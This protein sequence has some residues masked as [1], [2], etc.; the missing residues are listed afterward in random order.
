MYQ[1]LAPPTSGHHGPPI[2]RHSI[3]VYGLFSMMD[4]NMRACSLP[5]D[6]RSAPACPCPSI[7]AGNFHFFALCLMYSSV[8]PSRALHRQL[9]VR[10]GV[11]PNVTFT[12]SMSVFLPR[13]S[14]DRASHKTARCLYAAQP[15]EEHQL[16]HNHL[17]VQHPGVAAPTTATGSGEWPFSSYSTAI[18]SPPSNPTCIPT[19]I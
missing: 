1:L 5:T 8:V 7:S 18:R 19:A 2:V 13:S 17:L 4:G 6:S 16:Q 9:F 12:P 15:R 11:V 3:T 10:S 14:A